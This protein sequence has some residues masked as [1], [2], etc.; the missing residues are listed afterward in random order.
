MSAAIPPL[1]R[2]RP[3]R[4]PVQGRWCR[5]E[6]VTRS[7]FA[8]LWRAYSA[9]TAGRI[10]DYLPYGPFAD[11]AAFRAFAEATY[12]GEDPLF[13]AI[14]DA[15]TG[16]ATGVASLMRITPEH[17]VVEVG[18]INYAP[19][20][21]KTPAGTE[22]QFLLMR[23]VFEELG[24]RRYEWKCNN[25]NEGSRA[26]ALRYGFTFEGIFRNHM[27]VKGVNRDT[28]WFSITD[29]EWP[30][31]RDAFLAWLEPDNFDAAGRQK[32]PLAARRARG[33]QPAPAGEG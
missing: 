27:V 18:H 29:A 4:T 1:P 7:H 25:A 9:D 11:E 6:P 16:A 33:P 5:V 14:V 2:P 19:A 24:Y 12:L 31:I 23:R 17:G 10:W 15:R 22:A 21:Q 8:D 32:K 30:A 26:A 20:L 13:H 28:A 3:P